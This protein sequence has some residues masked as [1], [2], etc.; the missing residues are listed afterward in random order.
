M[1]EKIQLFKRAALNSITPQELKEVLRRMLKEA[2]RGDVAA[3]RVLLERVLGR[4]P[5][6][7]DDSGAIDYNPD[8]RFL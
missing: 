8:E 3:A 5:L 1:P 6:A 4:V 7:E 2:L